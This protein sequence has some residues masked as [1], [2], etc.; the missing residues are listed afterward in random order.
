M[1]ISLSLILLCVIFFFFNRRP[2]F[3]LPVTYLK[4][5]LRYLHIILLGILLL[6]IILLPLSLSFVSERKVVV[7]KDIPIQII[8][9][10]SLSMAANDMHPSRFAA[11]K[12]SLISL[13]KNLDGYY[14]SLI[15]FSGKPFVYVPFSSSS[16]AIAKKLA[17]MNL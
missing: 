6:S 10:V 15:A 13:V 3:I 1:R 7:E 8:L 17:A 12:N 16:S 14:L 9:D 4:Q 11:A 5:K 2:K